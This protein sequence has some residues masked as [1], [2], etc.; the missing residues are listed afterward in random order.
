MQVRLTTNNLHKCLQLWALEQIQMLIQ[1]LVFFK[2]LQ[3]NF[4][5][6]SK[7]HF[8]EEDL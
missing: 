5:P 7:K 1:S 6:E 4:W 2:H 8:V 3:L